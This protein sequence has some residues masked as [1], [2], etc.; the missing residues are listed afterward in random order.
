MSTKT[1]KLT[2]T[3]DLSEWS[4]NIVNNFTIM[5]KTKTHSKKA[6]IAFSNYIKTNN[7][8]LADNINHKLNLLLELW[9]SEDKFELSDLINV[10]E[11]HTN[12][13]SESDFVN[14]DDK[15]VFKLWKVYE[16]FVHKLIESGKSV[17][18]FYENNK[19]KINAVKLN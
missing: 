14:L 19:D 6:I 16:T 9:N 13:L 4:T 18:S 15:Y 10:I 12:N 1:E 7:I 8:E 17:I 3:N 2:Q 11:L 5:T